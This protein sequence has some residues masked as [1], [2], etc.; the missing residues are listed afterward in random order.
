MRISTL[1]SFGMSGGAPPGGV[2]QP[3]LA[4]TS[5]GAVGT[6]AL[7]SAVASSGQMSAPGVPIGRERTI[8]EHVEAAEHAAKYN[9]SQPTQHSH[10]GYLMAKMDYNVSQERA[11]EERA[12]ERE[13]VL[14]SPLISSL[15]CLPCS[16]FPS[17]LLLLC[18]ETHSR[19]FAR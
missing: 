3:A 5:S 11:I 8:E 15:F 17:L 19:L 14:G 10:S 2:P 12:R 6:G 4:V 7:S 13:S 18:I 1:I 16:F 9:P